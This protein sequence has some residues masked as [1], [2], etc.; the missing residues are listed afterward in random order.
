MGRQIAVTQK[1]G[2]LN[3]ALPNGQ[4]SFRAKLLAHGTIGHGQW[5]QPIS[6]VNPLF[7]TGVRFKPDGAERWRGTVMPVDDT[8]TI[9]LPVTKR[10]DGSLGTFIRSPERNIGVFYKA[11]RI[12]R[13]GNRIRVMGRGPGDKADSVLMSGAYD[14]NSD[15]MSLYFTARAL[16]FDFKREGDDSDFYPRGKHPAPYVYREPLRRDDG[17]PVGTLADGDIDQ[18]GI[19][20]FVRMLLETPM[21]SLDAQ[22]V[23]AILI[24]RHGKLVLEEY[25]HGENRDRLHETRSA[26]KSLTATLVGAAMEAGL[27]VDLATPVYK[28]MNGGTFPRGLEPRK[29]AMTLENLL[30]MSSGYFCDDSNPNAPGR[31]DTMTDDSKEPDYYKY[32]L[33]VPMEYEPGKVAVYCSANPNLAIGVL[34]RA[35]GEHPMDLFDRLL[36][37]PMQISRDAWFMSPALQPYGGGGVRMVPRDFMKLGQLMLDGGIWNGRRILSEEFVRRASSPLRDLNNI[38]Y[39]YLW[40]GVDFPYKD[41]TVHAFFAGGNGGQGVIVIPELDLVVA[42]FAANYATRVGLEIQQ[43]LTPR[44]ILPTVREPGDSKDAPVVPRKFEVKYGLKHK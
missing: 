14:S 8:I 43:G 12:E 41:R 44:Y 2:V 7:A 26:G 33:A 3:F 27:P 15:V 25:F 38:K 16:T 1:D 6:P 39:G 40:W 22:Q 21:D 23:D 36:G 32:T 20:S 31:E 28:V 24:A 30:T 34:W 29:R 13:D 10:P 37:D 11:D 18:K 9:Y 17:W 19:E 5:I 35:A 4:G 42:T